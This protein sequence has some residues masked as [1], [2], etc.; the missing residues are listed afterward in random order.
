MDTKLV[1]CPT[2][3]NDSV[4]AVSNPFRPFCSERC[5]SIDFGAWSSEHFRMAAEEPED[6][7]AF[8]DPALTDPKIQ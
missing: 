5:K 7:P 6:K 4:Y 8:S 3:K 2:C 1:T